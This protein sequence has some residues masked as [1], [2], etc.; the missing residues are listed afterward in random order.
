MFVLSSRV[1]GRGG[2]K[3]DWVCRIYVRYDPKRELGFLGPQGTTLGG[4]RKYQHLPMAML[5]SPERRIVPSDL[6]TKNKDRRPSARGWKIWSSSRTVP[7]S[8]MQL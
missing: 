3:G 2:D 6:R 8:T 4:E 7:E 1:K 5:R